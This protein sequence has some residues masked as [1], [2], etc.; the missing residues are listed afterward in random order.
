MVNINIDDWLKNTATTCAYHVDDF[1]RIRQ[2]THVAILMVLL[3]RIIAFNATQL[4]KR[5]THDN[6]VQALAKRVAM[7]G[8]LAA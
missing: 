3:V 6:S 2:V 8:L 1:A 7:L 4:V 5:W